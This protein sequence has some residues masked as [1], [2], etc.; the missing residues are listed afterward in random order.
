MHR[1]QW[2][3]IKSLIGFEEVFIPAGGGR[4]VKSFNFT[5]RM[6]RIVVKNSPAAKGTKSD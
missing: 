3:S 1:H 5:A 2:Q 4:V 6:K